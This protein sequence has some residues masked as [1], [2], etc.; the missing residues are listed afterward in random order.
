MELDWSEQSPHIRTL[1]APWQS[2]NGYEESVISAEEA[3]LGVRLPDPLRNFYQAWGRR[4]DLTQTYQSLLA[5][6]ELAWRPDALIFCAEN[7]GRNYWAILCKEL[8]K[9][10]PSVVKAYALPDWE[11]SEIASP[12]VWEPNYANV[13]DFLD[14]LTY[15]HALCGGALHG[16]WTKLFR[17]QKFQDRWLE[18]NWH[19]TTIGPMAFGLVDEYDDDLPFYV[20]HGQALAWGF[21]CSVATRSVED[22][23]EISQA[24]Q[25]SWEHRW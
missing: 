16:G 5:P 17:H 15:Q 7:Q 1:Y 6:G 25:I 12:L 11:M 3:R 10:N 8:E 19:R 2:G 21:G 4:K 20:R 24:L 14:T 22:L 9:V 18:Q 23:D 13:S